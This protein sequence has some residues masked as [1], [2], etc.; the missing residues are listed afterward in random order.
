MCSILF[1]V[2]CVHRNKNAALKTLRVCAAHV[3]TKTRPACYKPRSSGYSYRPRIPD[4]E[5]SRRRQGATGFPS[6]GLFI[7]FTEIK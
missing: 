6:N 2:R 3:A 1:V 4:W 7:K 5:L